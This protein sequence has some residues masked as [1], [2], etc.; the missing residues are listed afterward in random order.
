MKNN[1][2]GLKREMQADEIELTL[3]SVRAALPKK[4]RKIV[5]QQFV[6]DLNMLVQEPEARDN[7]RENLLSYTRVLENSNIGIVNYV[8]AVKYVSYKLLGFSNEESWVKTFPD[9]YQRLMDEGKN[10]VFVRGTVAA[11]NKGKIV[12]Q[13]LEESMM[14]TWVI[15]QDLF[16]KALNTQAQLMVSAKSEK[17]RSDAANSLL[18]HLKQPEVTK[19]SLDVRV[20]EDESVKELREVTLDLVKQQ[21][22]MI[23]SGAM[24]AKEVAEGKIIKGDFEV[25][26]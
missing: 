21:R 1:P 9:R 20:K 23:E 17:V 24:D 4:K 19:V 16:Q 2:F 3:D 12:A 10:A 14:P 25:V 8:H 26:G 22:L 7:F 13:I 15:N 11:Y 6:D 5:N 18:T